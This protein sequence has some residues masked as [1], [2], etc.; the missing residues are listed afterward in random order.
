M[1]LLSFF[2]E[3]G[4]IT[5]NHSVVPNGEL[6]YLSDITQRAFCRNK[7]SEEKSDWVGF[8]QKHIYGLSTGT[9]KWFGCGHFSLSYFQIN[10]LTTAFHCTK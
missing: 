9:V 3:H 7:H 8:L 5:Q 10:L 2:V 1:V 4:D 6:I